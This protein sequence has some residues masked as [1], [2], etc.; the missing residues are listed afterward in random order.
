VAEAPF[1]A[2][3]DA[4]DLDPYSDVEDDEAAGT[5]NQ[6]EAQDNTVG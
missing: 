6:S 3:E 5:A 2:E 1:E 4:E